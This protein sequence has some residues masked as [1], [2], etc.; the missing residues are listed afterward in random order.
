MEIINS[1]D[2][3]YWTNYL[4]YSLIDELAGSGEPTDDQMAIELK[5]QKQF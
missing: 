5:R 3:K 4:D 2:R 1:L